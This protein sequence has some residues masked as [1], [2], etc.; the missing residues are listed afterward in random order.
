M[1]RHDGWETIRYE[2]VPGRD[3]VNDVVSEIVNEAWHVHRHHPESWKRDGDFKD[4]A[5][6]RIGVLLE[7]DSSLRA[8]MLAQKDRVL[9]MLVYRAAELKEAGVDLRDATGAEIHPAAET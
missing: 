7:D 6:A 4:R 1:K 5:A 2:I 3:D 9:S 8:S